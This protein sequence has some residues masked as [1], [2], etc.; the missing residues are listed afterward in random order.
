VRN[1]VTFLTVISKQFFFNY[2]L[3]VQKQCLTDFG[4]SK[5]ETV[6]V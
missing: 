4:R 6:C 5:E 3:A 1:T 2:M